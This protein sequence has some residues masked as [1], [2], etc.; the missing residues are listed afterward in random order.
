MSVEEV[1][2]TRKIKGF[3]VTV[4][5]EGPIRVTAVKTVTKD[6]ESFLDRIEKGLEKN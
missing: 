5:R 2:E 1:S 4:T 6:V 3:K